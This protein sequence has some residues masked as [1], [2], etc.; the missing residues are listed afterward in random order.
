MKPCEFDDSLALAEAA[1]AQFL[2]KT[3]GMTIRVAVNGKGDPDCAVFDIGYL[4]TG[5]HT[6]FQAHAYHFR[7][8]LD[9][10]R[11]SREEVQKAIMRLLHSFPVNADTNADSE[12]RE[13]ANVKVFRIAPQTQAVS[14]IVT[15]DVQPVKDAKPIPCWTSTVQFDVV[16]KA[17]F[18]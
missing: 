10:Y 12:L 15:A 7:A 2:H 17:R 5:E 14:E 9:I 1:C 8:K 3:T 16:F 11:R 6:L 4:Y 13:S 18:E